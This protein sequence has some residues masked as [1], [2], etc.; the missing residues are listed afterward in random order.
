MCWP[1]ALCTE[2]PITASD[3]KRS[4]SKDGIK[5]VMQAEAFLRE[6]KKAHRRHALCQCRKVVMY[7][8]TCFDWHGSYEEQVL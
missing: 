4:I 6:T 7:G 1:T 8:Q 2:H 5:K 3:M